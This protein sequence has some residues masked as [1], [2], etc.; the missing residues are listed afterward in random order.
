MFIL[1]EIDKL[2]S[3]FRG[4]PSSALLEVLDPE[5]NF[6]FSDHYLEV[7]FDLSK[8]LFIATANLLE[9]IPPA[10]R[11]RME[12]IELP[13]YTEEDKLEIAR[14]HLLPRQLREHGLEE[15]APKLDD[16]ALRGV[17]RNYTREAGLRNLER[18]LGKIARKLARRAVEGDTGSFHVRVGDLPG[19]LGPAH[20]EPEVAGRVQIPGVSVG[21]AVTEAGGEILFIEATRMKGKGEL[22]I[23]GSVR[24]VMRESAMT[25]VSL[26]RT[27]ARALGLDAKLFSESDIHI[28]IPAG[29]IP[30]DGPERGHRDRDRPDLAP[31]RPAGSAGPGDDRRDHAAR[32]GLAGRRNQGEDP[33]GAARGG[34]AR[35]DP[36]GQR[37]GPDRDSGRPDL[38]SQDRA[39]GEDRAS[40]S[41]RVRTRPRAGPPGLKRA[42]LLA[43]ALAV[44]ACVSRGGYEAEVAR[45]RALSTDLVSCKKTMLDESKSSQKLLE[46]KKSLDAERAAL[47]AE[48]QSQRA[49]VDDLRE[50]LERERMARLLSDE[51]VAGSYRKLTESLDAEVK[52]GQ[53]QIEQ[54]PGR[55]QIRAADQIL[56]DSGSAD[57]KPE[58]RA[59]IGKVAR[60]IKGVANREV[61]VEGH[62]D[63]VAVRSAKFTSNWDLSA[64]RAAT[65][66]KVLEEGGVSREAA[67]GGG[68]RPVPPARAE[69][70][71]REPRA[72]P[73]DRDRAGRAARTRHG[74]SARERLAEI[75]RAAL[76]AVHAG[77]ALERALAEADPGAGPFALL[78]AG[79]A[80][81]AMAEAAQR[82]LGARIARGAVT[83]KTG[84]ARTLAGLRVREAGHP[85]PDAA[86]EAAAREALALAAGLGGAEELLVLISGG[87]SALWCAPAAGI[88]L[89]DKRRATELLLRAEVEIRELNTVRRHL[90][91]IKGGG[92]A[93]AARGRPVHL[94]AVSDVRGDAPADIG[95]GPA[96][97]DPSRAADALAILRRHGLLDAMPASVRAH[98]EAGGSET[99]GRAARA[100]TWSRASATRWPRPS[101]LREAHG[102]RVRVLPEA[103]YGEV[104][105]VAAALAGAARRARA[106]GVDLL[107]AGGE[108]TVAVRGSGLG[109]RA[110][111][112]ALRLAL[113][114]GDSLDF[115]A[116]CAGSDGSDGPTDAAGAFADARS[117][118]RAAER[119]LDP[120]AHLARSDVHPLLAAT[121]DLYVTGPTETNVA[122]L[123]LVLLA[124]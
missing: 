48:V 44:T 29:A 7:P 90:S 84:Y 38:G 17:I 3:D 80:A 50:K 45:Q 16:E 1:D 65:V 121:G 70:Q 14:R 2:G 54:L 96:S 51:E 74:V 32:Q 108:P 35:A 100:S 122:D 60:S 72:Q 8:V 61:R 25:A 36:R 95:S 11:D 13:G 66:A 83:T 53:I 87:A 73:A 18:E 97:A 22:K 67:R 34:D 43:W 55:L 103:L 9:N 46:E 47:L 81:C 33:R 99:A 26:V 19:L 6:A 101:A 49:G 76:A 79:K 71:R 102:L 15:R 31:A 4:D 10:L 119:G 94:Y 21:L 120:R 63:D 107:V 104:G 40:D 82:A 39:G 24:D 52:S 85:L 77:R 58:G 111:E 117:L 93:R 105:E 110:Q 62:T 109:G 56:F 27:Y 106:E 124:R 69:R 41:D 92:L 5:Q 30:K 98:L 113:E 23:T 91:A 88:S 89:A 116:L 118:A 64:A 114:L 42:W 123:A 112:L 37:E 75:H 28:H 59:V 57:L 20:F 115:A 68:I 78:A 12:V 86:S